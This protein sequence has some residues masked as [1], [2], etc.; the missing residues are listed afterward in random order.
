MPPPPQPAN[1]AG[2]K[3]YVVNYRDYSRFLNAAKTAKPKWESLVPGDWAA[4]LA[5]Y[6]NQSSIGVKSVS[7]EQ[8]EAF[9]EW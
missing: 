8:A 7:W 3:P 5:R 1:F 2:W 4:S 9:V 6:A